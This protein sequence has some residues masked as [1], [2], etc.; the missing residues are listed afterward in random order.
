MPEYGRYREGKEWKKKKRARKIKRTALI[1][2][3]LC[4]GAAKARQVP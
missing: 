4:A 1:K 3:V 2:S